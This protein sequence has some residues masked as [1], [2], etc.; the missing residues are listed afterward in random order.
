MLRVLLS[1]LNVAIFQPALR[2]CT[3][4]V[5]FVLK[6]CNFSGRD[7]KVYFALNNCGFRA[8]AAK[9]YFAYAYYFRSQKLRLSSRSC[10]SELHVLLS[11]SKGAC[12][13]L[14]Q[15]LQFSSRSCD[16]VWD[17]PSGAAKVYLRLKVAIFEPELL[18]SISRTCTTL[19]RN[20]CDFPAGAAKVNFTYYFRT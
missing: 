3:S 18:E 11:Y 15:K 16:R 2:K 4:R 20:F 5:I 8:G 17:F 9:V 13:F 7:A 19:V 1:Y 14:A 6:S 12:W 10:E